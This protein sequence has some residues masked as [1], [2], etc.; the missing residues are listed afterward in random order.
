MGAVR[1]IDASAPPTDVL[2]A[3]R[4]LD[5]H[6]FVGRERAFRPLDLGWLPLLALTAAGG[7]V[8][9]TIGDALSRSSRSSSQLLFWT[10]LVILFAPV[11]FRLCSAEPRRSER[12]SLVVLLGLALYLVK[13]VHDPF[14]FTYADELVHAGNV[15]QILS[16]HHLYG[17]NSILPVTAKYPGLESVAAALS[18]T[19]GLGTFGAGLIVVAVARLM[20]MLALYLLFERLSGSARVAGIGAA[21][22]AANA[23]FLFF[24]AQFSYESLALPL[25]VVVMFA[26]AERASADGPV[27]RLW[28][29]AIL[30]VTGAVVVS[31]HLTSYALVIVLAALSLAAAA[32]GVPR[33]RN[34]WPFALAALAATAAWLLVVASATVG[35]LT[36]VLTR[37][38][39]STIDTVSGNAAP[40]QLFSSDATSYQAPLLERA[41][42]IGSVVLLAVA[43]AA[44]LRIV[45]R[46]HRS[47]PFA[48]VFAV[49]GTAFFGLL[50]F[51]FAS[52]AW[53]TANR[54]SEFLFIGLSFVVALAAV[55]L[56]PRFRVA[57]LGVAA[58]T[59]S[60]TVVFAGGVIAG[61]QP[62]LRLS[63]PYVIAAGP[64]GI[65]APG[66]QLARWTA[67][68][69]GPGQRIVASDS[70][71]R[72]LLAYA[73]AVALVGRGD[74]DQ[75]DA[76]N[77]LQTPLLASWEADSLRAHRIAYVAVDRRRRSFDAVRGYFFDRAG[78]ADDLLDR[79]VVAKFDRFGA[80]R[81]Y[82]S[83]AIKLYRIGGAS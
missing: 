59:M 81:I 33:S 52:A 30:A 34:P 82:D 49:A 17:T 16:S 67:A 22:Y 47:S 55:E 50:L 72:L 66:R 7:L 70:D 15:N 43:A 68:N 6:E 14:G 46:R 39:T 28:A 62:L 65:E 64:N 3:P 60:L 21:V 40:R 41:V 10:G 19:S 9:S 48:L 80:D 36:P 26:V 1:V 2:E 38:I 20:M 5:E 27:R 44:G 69:V 25:L 24:D 23:N 18:A 56:L 74:K 4:A 42:G 35:Y 76:V 8:V 71:G 12:L 32:V 77:I 13:V 83:G 73:D 78:V 63:Q 53:E 37:A 31:H 79:R 45:W 11:A 54:S 61:W 75:P 29:A 51:R 58:I 57:R